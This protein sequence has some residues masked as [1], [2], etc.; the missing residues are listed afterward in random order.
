MNKSAVA[1]ISGGVD[2]ILAAKLAKDAGIEVHGLY[3]KS[4]FFRLP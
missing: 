2:S 1:L 4:V 3:M